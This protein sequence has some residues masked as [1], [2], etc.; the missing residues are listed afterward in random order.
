MDLNS[1]LAMSIVLPLHSAPP[2]VIDVPQYTGEM[3][4]EDLDENPE[5]V[6]PE[7]TPPS[8]D[9]MDTIEGYQNIGFSGGKFY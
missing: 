1:L 4:D 3:P 9:K 6:P 8:L 5:A 2:P 7:I